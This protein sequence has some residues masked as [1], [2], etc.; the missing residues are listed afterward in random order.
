MCRML[1]LYSWWLGISNY[2]YNYTYI[3]VY[4]IL[5]AVRD[6]RGEYL[7]IFSGVAYKKM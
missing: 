7:V 1:G 5:M 3:L 6:N 4:I 2:I